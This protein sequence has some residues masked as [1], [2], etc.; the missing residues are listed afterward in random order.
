M[1]WR[2]AELL[3][4]VRVEIRQLGVRS[5][6]L[7]KI[8]RKRAAPLVTEMARHAAVDPK[9]SRCGVR[10][11]P[12]RTGTRAPLPAIRTAPDFTQYFTIS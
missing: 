11:E 1:A 6:R 5:E 9:R 10:P 2:A 3:E 7:G 12:G 8:R 4:R